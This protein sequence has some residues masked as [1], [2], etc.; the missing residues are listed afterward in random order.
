MET[1]DILN[2]QAYVDGEVGAAQKRRLE[3]L[4]ASDAAARQWVEELRF[5]RDAVR[6]NE[7]EILCPESREFYW[8]KI[9]REIERGE[10]Q[11]MVSARHIPAWVWRYL[12][13]LA[14]VAA[15]AV[16][17]VVLNRGASPGDTAETGEAG[18]PEASSVVFRSQAEGMTVVWLQNTAEDHPFTRF[19]A[20]DNL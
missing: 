1:K 17:L 6:G 14:G 11:P 8:S 16:M 2:L 19:N 3:A 7:P 18:L 15:L 4:I 20:E 9:A 10:R 5:T 13:P 12:S